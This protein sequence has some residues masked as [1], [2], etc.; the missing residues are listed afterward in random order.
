[1]AG[2]AVMLFLAACGCATSRASP[3]YAAVL[4]QPYRGY[5]RDRIEDSS[6]LFR[7]SRLRYQSPSLIAVGTGE[8]GRGLM[9]DP[10]F[11]LPYP[12]AISSSR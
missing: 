5:R 12:S 1:M 2:G 10:S 3:C 6:P 11:Y 7:R 9:E 4:Y 8:S